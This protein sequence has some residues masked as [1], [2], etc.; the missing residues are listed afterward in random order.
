MAWR[1]RDENMGEQDTS[2]GDGGGRG[3]EPLLPEKQMYNLKKKCPSFS[4]NMPEK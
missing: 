2:L 3:A 1:T 4:K